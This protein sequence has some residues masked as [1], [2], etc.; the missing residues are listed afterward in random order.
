MRRRVTRQEQLDRMKQWRVDNK[1]RFEV[2]RNKWTAENMDRVRNSKLL[3]EKAKRLGIKTSDFSQ[4]FR[5]AVI[6]LANVERKVKE[7]MK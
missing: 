6:S 3:Y 2:A 5:D 1:D 4:E 7:L